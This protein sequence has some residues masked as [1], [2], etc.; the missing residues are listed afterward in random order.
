MYLKSIEVNGFKSFANKLVFKFNDGITGIV[1]PNGSGKSNVGDAVRWVLGEQSAKQLRGAKM[2]DVIF[3]GTELR[4]PQG[5]AYVA[6]TLD[7]SDHKLPIDY[8]EVTVARRVYRSGESEYLING[9]VSR[10]K[11]VSSLFF[12]TGVGKEGYSIIGQGQVEKI[13]SGKPEEKRELFD[14]AAGIV[15]YKKNKAAT[16][17]TLENERLNLSRVNDILGELEKQ[18]GPL[19]E[20]SETARRYLIFKDE[21]KRLDINAFLLD[22]DDSSVQMDDL[23]NKLSIVTEDTKRLQAELDQAKD[24]Y[25]KIESQIESYDE[26]IENTKNEIHE[27]KLENQRFDGD[28]NVINQ[29][30]ISCKQNESTLMEQIERTNADIAKYK[31]ELEAYY[32]GKVQLDEK[33]DSADD[34]LD[35]A[36]KK[37]AEIQ[38]RITDGEREIEDSKTEIIELLN[39]G[40]TLKAKVGR[41]DTMLENINLRKRELESRFLENK[42]E[43]ERNAKE[44]EELKSAIKQFEEEQEKAGKELAAVAEHLKQNGA[45]FEELNKRIHDN[46]NDI[47]SLKSKKE[48]LR[49]LTERYDGYGVSI[50]KVMEKKSSEKGIVGVVADIITVSKKYETAIETALGGNIK[51]IVTEDEAVAKRMIAYLKENH[52]GRATFLPISSINANANANMDVLNEQG[53]IGIA[54][55]LVDFDARYKT[56]MEYLLGRIYVANDI[57]S[58]IRISRKYRQTLRIVTIEGDLITPGGAMTGGSFKNA[59]NLLGRKRELDEMDELIAA[60]VKEV[61]AD[62]AAVLGLDA[63]REQLK[64][65]R[66]E[67]SDML[68][69]IS[70]QLNTYNLNYE[71]SV[72][73]TDEIK[74][75]Y[76]RIS[77]ENNELNTQ[78]EE[79]NGNKAE[80]TSSNQKQEE[81]VKYLEKRIEELEA[82]VEKSKKALAVSAEEIN[83]LNIDFNVVKQQYDFAVQNIKRVTADES[84]AKETLAGLKAKLSN[85][86][87][88]LTGLNKKIEE[89][90]VHFDENLRIIGVK[91]GKLAELT[92]RRGSLNESHKTFFEKREE[93]SAEISGLDKSSFRLSADIEKVEEHSESLNN[94]M[95]EEYELTYNSAAEF[96]D[97]SFRDAASLKREITAVKGKIKQL[98]DVNVNAIEDYRQVSERYEFLKNQHDDIVKA[99]ENLVNIINE[100]DRAMR[101][102]FAEKFK[103]I[104]I[105]FSKVFRELFGGGKADLELVDEEDILETGIRIIAQ[106]PGK[107]LQNMLQLS[108][109]EKSLTAIALLF[110]IQSLKPSPFCLLDEIEAALDDS[111]VKRFAKYLHKLTKDTQFIVITHRR[112][113]MEAA[114]ILYG[115]TMQEKGVSTLVSVNMIENELED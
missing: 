90:K 59:S 39:E 103:E 9:T 35:A 20:Q 13:L 46:S 75:S 5:S 43:E 27:K 66:D 37:N 2:E 97:E 95:W 47:V 61:E 8:N 85:G 92:E 70:I 78:I 21:L 111:N 100:L 36:I 105:M 16:E 18:V 54:A 26:Q 50:K 74:N 44:T 91:E 17:K 83:K 14:E 104:K 102:Q 114:D 11:D 67:L 64:K 87:N 113:T 96:K 60:K 33:L 12:D 53:I 31:E 80:L 72:S 19:K 55:S 99:E 24:D 88:E 22:V 38:S 101:E 1:G 4:K 58:A 109:G 25:E 71:Q 94:Y 10:L 63:E 68:Q 106:P 56:I 81:T 45:S 29:Q 79:I 30:I 93:L 57:D 32:A 52:L 42:S 51:N 69:N 62:K 73:R 49:N 3:S 6:I 112:G 110:A 107:K 28:I 108:G 48:A 82:F 84:L 86:E 89:L 65:R 7:N 76:A 23:K 41:Y 77:R 98:G 115:I 15:K 34:V 40:G